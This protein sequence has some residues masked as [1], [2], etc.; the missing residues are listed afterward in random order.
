MPFELRVTWQEKCHESGVGAST[1]DGDDYDPIDI[2]KL[3]DFL[4]LQVENRE[5]GFNGR[6]S[7]NVKNPKSVFHDDVMGTFAL[8]NRSCVSSCAFCGSDDHRNFQCEKLSKLS[9]SD[10]YELVKTKSLCFNCL[11]PKH[12]SK[13][14]KSKS[15][16]KRCKKRHNSLLCSARKDPSREKKDSKPA[17]GSGVASGISDADGT[18]LLVSGDKVP[19]HGVYPT[20]VARVNGT[21]Q[22]GKVRIMFDGCSN[23]TF[24]T[25]EAA[26]LHKF[27][28]IGSA[29]LNINVFGEGRVSRSVNVC[30]LR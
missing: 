19:T 8:E 25:P 16:C 11:S 7:S 24:V 4:L 27:P 29:R 2:E 12:R 15:S 23:Q 10:R 9:V 28:I 6:L 26:A 14:C 3:L 18:S 20:L 21:G 1:I 17:N 22:N 30:E 13:E 5:L